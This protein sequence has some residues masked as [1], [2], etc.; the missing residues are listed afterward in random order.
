MAHY[1]IYADTASKEGRDNDFTVF[2]CWGFLN[3]NGRCFAYLID[4]YR[5]KLTTPKL[6]RAAKDFWMKH[7]ENEKDIPLIK[8]AIEDKS[9][10]IGLIQLLEEETNIPVTRLYPEKDKVARANDILPRMESGQVLFPK[11]APWLLDLEKELLSFSAKKGSNKKDQV[12]TLTY[13]IKDILFNPADEKLKPMDYS[14]LLNEKI[15]Y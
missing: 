10:G 2:M 11:D 15:F 5:D 8:F 1:A 6:L 14:A 7:Y 3:K 9:S 4:V 13:A 12:D